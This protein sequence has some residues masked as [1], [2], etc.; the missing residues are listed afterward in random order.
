MFI[1][2]II[3]HNLVLINNYI[4]DYVRYQKW[5]SA[6]SGE[7]TQE[8][9]KARMIIRIHTIEKGLS[10]ENTRLG[11]GFDNIKLMIVLMKKYYE[12]Y[13]YDYVVKMGLNA[14][15]AYIQFHNSKDYEVS[16]VQEL[17]DE[18]LFKIKEYRS[19]NDTG[20]INVSK[21][22]MYCNAMIDFR[23]F[24]ECRHSVRQFSGQEVAND[25]I[26]DA[27]SIAQK[28]PSVCNRQSSRIY[29]ISHSD[30]IRQIIEMQSGARSFGE[31][32][33]KVLIIT[34]DLSNFVSYGERN[35]SWIDGGMFSMSLVYALHSKGLGTCCLNWCKEKRV[36]KEL[37][38]SISISETD[39]II[40]VIAVGHLKESFVVAK[41]PRKTIDEIMFFD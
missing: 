41:S 20:V 23:A 30:K 39:N 26:V 16:C 27:V 8:K 5:S 25:S 1:I 17:Y 34:S 4:Y 29:V 3:Y 31:E 36:D 13:G 21:S 19:S 15:D 18:C 6:I 12:L 22:E 38:K 37:R 9:M 24:C 14:L 33:N 28:T 40:M 2:K 32:I 35:Q 7:N 11:F 10:L